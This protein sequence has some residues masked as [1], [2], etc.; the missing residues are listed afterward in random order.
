MKAAIFSMT[1]D[2]EFIIKIQTRSD[3][4]IYLKKS[5]IEYIEILPDK[6]K[7]L[8][9]IFTKSGKI[10]TDSNLYDSESEILNIYM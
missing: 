6:D 4:I 3:V 5:E 1:E 8:V 7:Y 9:C 2:N 10:I